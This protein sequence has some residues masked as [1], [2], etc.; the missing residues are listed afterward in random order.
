MRPP[1]ATAACPPFASI[2]LTTPSPRP[3]PRR[4]FARGGYEGAGVREIGKGAGVTAMLINRYFGSKEQL[5]AEVVAET[6]ATPSILTQEIITSPTSG[7]DIA[8]ALIDQTKAGA[9]PL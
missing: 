6:V 3:R 9:I 2:S 4:A 1:N 8:A 5:F 7:A